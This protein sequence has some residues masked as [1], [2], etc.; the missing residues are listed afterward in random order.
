MKR[1]ELKLKS[2]KELSGNVFKL[3]LCLLVIAVFS[4]VSINISV[5]LTFAPMLKILNKLPLN[6]E[7]S[8]SYVKNFMISNLLSIPPITY[9]WTAIIIIFSS[10]V[11]PALQFSFNKLCLE[12]SRGK[13]ISFSNFF[14]N[15]SKLRIILKIFLLAL[16]QQ[17][18]IVLWT[19][20]FIIPGIIK[21]FSYS[22]SYYVLMDNP[23]MTPCEALKE[24]QRLM[25][26]HKWKFFVLGLSFIW[27]NILAV[28][29]LGIAYIY[30]IPYTQITYANFYNSLQLK[31]Q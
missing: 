9:V 2:R 27:W 3:F 10:I 17:I 20:L 28:L 24:S 21:S 19:L 4:Y 14:E 26:G 16:L 25:V 6:T 18:L 13:E 5:N 15:I 11:L 29:T 12:L 23:N 30:V 22:M 8:L 7:M 1:K 31:T